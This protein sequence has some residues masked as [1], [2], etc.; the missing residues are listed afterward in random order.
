MT[1][2]T[3]SALALLSRSF[4]CLL[5]ATAVAWGSF[6]LPLFWQQARLNSLASKLLQGSDFTIQSLLSELPRVEAVEQSFSCHATALHSVVIL[7]LAII[8][9]A[10]EEANQKLIDSSYKSLNDATRLALAC[11]P[12]DAFAW[13]TLFWLDAGVNG[14]NLNN[15]NYLRLSYVFGANEG[16]I[17]LWRNRLAITLVNSLP[18]DLGDDAIN[19]FVELVDTGGLYSETAAVFARA[20]PSIQTRIIERLET[21]RAL[22]RE[23][24]ARAL[25]GMGLNV[26]IPSVKMP[27]VRPWQ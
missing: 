15:T 24:F 2:T 7:R 23:S 8:N 21:S 19:E 9:Q 22:V 6:A 16:W 13:L 3:H 27:E 17:G 10:I 25:Y 20:A 5:G 1:S 4:V 26:D 18:V 11:A 12:T 14:L